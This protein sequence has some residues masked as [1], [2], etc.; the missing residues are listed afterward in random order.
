MPSGNSCLIEINSMIVGCFGKAPT[1][2]SLCV[3]ATA[4]CTELFA[5]V[6]AAGEAADGAGEVPV[7]VWL[8]DGDSVDD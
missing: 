1:N 4:L 5:G 2:S 7:F 8:G 3:N 6:D